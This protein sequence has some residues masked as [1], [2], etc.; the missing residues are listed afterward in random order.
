ML[1]MNFTT[2]FLRKNKV[3]PILLL[4]YMKV[5][6]ISA[7][8]LLT[9]LGLQS[10]D[11]STP[12]IGQSIFEHEQIK[13][14][15]SVYNVQST[16]IR[17]N[18]VYS[19]TSQAYLGKYTDAEFGPFSADF[20]TQINCPEN[21]TFPISTVSIDSVGLELYYS[22]YYGDSLATMKVQVDSLNRQIIDDGRNKELYYTNYDVNQYYN[23]NAQALAAKVFAP[24]DL[25]VS[26]NKRAEKGYYPSVNLFFNQ[27]FGKYLLQKYKENPKNYADS[28]AFNT[29][30]LKGFYVHITQGEGAMIYIGDIWMRMRV[31]YNLKTATGKDSLVYRKVVMAATREVFMSTR[32][33]N[34]PSSTLDDSKTYLRTPAGLCTEIQLT[35]LQKMYNEHKNDTLNSASLNILKYRDLEKDNQVKTKNPEYV[36]L[37]RKKDMK[38]FFENNQLPDNKTSFL[39]SYNST[40]NSYSFTKLNRLFTVIFS[41]IKNNNGIVP[42]DVDKFVLVPVTVQKDAQSNIIGVTNNLEVTSATLIKGRATDS[43]LKLEVIFTKQ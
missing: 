4:A 9:A 15:S 41:E 16:T 37:M 19:K 32:F 10:C 3:K 39:T 43:P 33:E 35:E 30:V 8:I 11:D 42:T 27:D 17:L 22:G 40:T 6:F 31:G 28:Y 5:K 36:V 24:V 26:A 13:A 2:K 20:V 23:S 21:F 18:S 38:N 12:G 29:Q 1:V 7:I 14:E 25:T 34:K